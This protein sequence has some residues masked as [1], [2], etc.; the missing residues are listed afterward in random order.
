MNVEEK[1]IRAVNDFSILQSQIP[2][3]RQNLTRKTL[4]SKGRKYMQ[5]VKSYFPVYGKV[6][7]R[8]KDDTSRE[9]CK[10]YEIHFMSKQKRW[11]CVLDYAIRLENREI[12]PPP[13]FLA[14]C[15][16]G[17]NL[18]RNIDGARRI[19]AIA[20]ANWPNIQCII[21]KKEK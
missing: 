11:K 15:I 12:P 14:P 2:I 17:T 4:N 1:K 7:S 13:V 18:Y 16:T 6:I 10:E 20:E 3:I 9:K 21:L 5:T 8:W 19:M